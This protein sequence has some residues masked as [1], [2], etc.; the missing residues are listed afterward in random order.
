MDECDQLADKLNEV[1][2][3]L[4]Q[5]SSP[6]RS[7]QRFLCG[8]KERDALEEDRHIRFLGFFLEIYVSKVFYNLT[9]DVPYLE[10]V[11]KEIQVNFYRSVG[12]TLC[13]ISSHL[14]DKNYEKLYSCY[15]ELGD[16]Y[17]NAVNDLNKEL[18]K[19]TAYC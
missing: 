5:N 14:R 9:G 17:I 12:E 8:W 16:A 2:G 4:R 15:G 6:L 19:G 7:L 13:N 10:T 11:T 3:N 1:G 18:G